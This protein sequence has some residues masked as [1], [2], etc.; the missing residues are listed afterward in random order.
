MFQS[1]A[2]FKVTDSLPLILQ[3]A[4][5]LQHKGIKGGYHLEEV[6]RT[7]G[8]LDVLVRFR[9]RRDVSI[10]IPAYADSYDLSNIP[11]YEHE[12]IGLIHS[13]ISKSE[14]PVLLLDCGADIGL[15]SALLV[16]AC[17]CID[18]VFAFEPNPRSFQRL[19]RNLQLL[20]VDT[21]A[22]NVAVAN[23]SGRGELRYPEHD[24]DDHAA[25]IVPVEQGD[26]P[27]VKIDE[28]DLASGCR[29]LCKIDVE[30]GE[31]AVI[32]GAQKTLSSSSEFTVVFEAHR[33]QV[34]RTGIDPLK[35]V[36]LLN[37]FKKCKAV[38]A[39]EPD[40]VIDFDYPFFEQFPNRIY[41]I[42]VFSE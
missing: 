20:P 35:V 7:R 38:V 9:L 33:E 16:S 34:K 14:K 32:E 30:G 19:E 21:E 5:F 10:D 8:W 28:L 31:L 11:G 15:L 23:F 42:C 2:N 4:H 13:H 27:V 6:A 37:E 1:K 26:I 22:K 25:F 41:N 24:S 3:I 18:K 36:S 12:L 40:K 17:D 29:V 39:E